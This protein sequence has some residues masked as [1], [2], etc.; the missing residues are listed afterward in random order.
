MEKRL[1]LDRI[2]LHTAHVATGNVKLP[3]AVVA[4]LANSGLTLRNGTTMPAGK[5]PNPI[6]IKRF[7]Q[8]RCSFANVLVQ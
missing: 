5:A 7:D 4:N 6:A 2:A 3:S 8:F 1:L